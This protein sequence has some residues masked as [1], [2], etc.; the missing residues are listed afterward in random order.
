[1]AAVSCHSFTW[2]LSALSQLVGESICLIES[3]P[4]C[5]S[6]YSF[7]SF[8]EYLGHCSIMGGFLYPC[9]VKCCQVCVSCQVKCSREVSQESCL[10]YCVSPVP[11]LFYYIALQS[12]FCF[13]SLMGETSFPSFDE[14]LPVDINT[15]SRKQA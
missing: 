15:S 9:Q 3:L 12:V 8:R 11:T 10:S 6:S 4:S 7:E 2:H 5:E 14:S 1:M 13:V